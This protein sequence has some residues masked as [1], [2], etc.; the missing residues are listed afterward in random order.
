MF[1]ALTAAGNKLSL[2]WNK[3]KTEL[4]ISIHDSIKLVRVLYVSKNDKCQ[5]FDP[6]LAVYPAIEGLAR[7]DQQPMRHWCK[8]GEVA[9]YN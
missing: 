2:E 4:V 9:M 5:C 3:N 7:S 6:G 1:V 8:I